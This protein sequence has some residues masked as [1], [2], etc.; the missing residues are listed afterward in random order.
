VIPE[1]WKSSLRVYDSHR[2]Q[3]G[4]YL[5]LVEEET[6]VRPPYGLIRTGDGEY[7]RIEN[8]QAL[9]DWVLGIAERIRVGQA[10]DRAVDP[11][12]AEGGAMPGVRNAGALRAEGGVSKRRGQD[13][14]PRL[15]GISP[16]S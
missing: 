9:C 1:E 6:G 2:A 11:G 7:V 15:R 3:L 12:Q 14:N 4:V 13:S 5:I 16:T 10:G 8:D